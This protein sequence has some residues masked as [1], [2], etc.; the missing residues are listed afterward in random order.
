MTKQSRNPAKRTLAGK[1]IILTRAAG[2]NEALAARISEAGGLPF[3]FATIASVPVADDS[4]IRG[5]LTQ[6]D[7]YSYIVFTSAQAV[8]YFARWRTPLPQDGQLRYAAVGSVTADALRARGV[9]DVLVPDDFRAEGLIALFADLALDLK[10]SGA[11]PLHRS[12]VT[13]EVRPLLAQAQAACPPAVLIPRALVARETLPQALEQLGFEVTVAPLYETV[14]PEVSADTLDLILKTDP[15]GYA[16]LAC[17]GVVFTSPSTVNNFVT[18]IESASAPAA[19]TG[20]A[21]LLAAV[22]C[23]SIGSPTTAALRRLGVPDEHIHQA[24]QATTDSL[25][26]ALST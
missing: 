1:R 18:L 12:T 21:A 15:E 8:E 4:V 13:E 10:K 20:A 11:L 2:K 9:T 25:F 3:I 6:I 7:H 17:D 22:D 16:H 26:D 23:Y 24:A 14:L 19:L 5:A